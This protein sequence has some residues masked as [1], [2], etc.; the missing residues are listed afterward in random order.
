[1]S[2]VEQRTAARERLTTQ[3]AVYLRAQAEFQ[4]A[5]SA[6]KDVEG[7]IQYRIGLIAQLENRVPTLSNGGIQIVPQPTMGVVSSEPAPQP[8]QPKFAS[9]D[10]TEFRRQFTGAM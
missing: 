10:A 2:L 8:N 3:H 1:V 6:M 7:D 9:V 5:E 4:A